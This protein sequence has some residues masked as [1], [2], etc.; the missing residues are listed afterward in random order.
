MMG[1]GLFC[2]SAQ[3]KFNVLSV[4]SFCAVQLH[5]CPGQGLSLTVLLC[6]VHPGYG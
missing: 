3:S 2:H 1:Q 6:V 5:L 4:L